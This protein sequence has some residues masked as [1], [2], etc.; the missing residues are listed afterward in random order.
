MEYSVVAVFS[1][2]HTPYME[3]IC[4]CW[5]ISFS[6]WTALLRLFFWEVVKRKLEILHICWHDIERS[7][8][9]AFSF[10]LWM[11]AKGSLK[12][13]ML[14][15]G[16]PLNKSHS[17][18]TLRQHVLQIKVEVKGTCSV[19]LWTC[20][21]RSSPYVNQI[22]ILKILFLFLHALNILLFFQKNYPEEIVPSLLPLSFQIGMFTLRTFIEFSFL[23]TGHWCV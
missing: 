22:H 7:F 3:W 19:I 8:H 2:N 16:S 5:A 20:E 6:S 21:V 12:T 13:K 4:N 18:H 11:K 14:P 1:R 17:S 15:L 23:P 9:F 10:Y